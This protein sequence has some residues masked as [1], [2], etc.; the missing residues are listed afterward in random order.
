LQTT[1]RPAPHLAVTTIA[2]F[3]AYTAANLSW[4]TQPFQFTVFSTQSGFGSIAAGWILSSEIGLAALVSI[5]MG[6]FSGARTS[7]SALAAGTLLCVI[8][9]V[10]TVLVSSF[11]AIIVSR[12]VAGLGEGLLIAD[13]NRAVAQLDQPEKRYGQINA[14]MNLAGFLL[15]LC[16]PVVLAPLH[17]DRAIFALLAVATL[18]CLAA[19]TLYPVNAAASP[20][21]GA[22]AITGAHAITGSNAGT[23]A[24]SITRVPRG[25]GGWRGWTVCA[26]VLLTSTGVSS[27]YPV[28]ESLGR[29]SG[30]SEGSLDSAL[31]MA[32]IGAIIGSYGGAWIDARI[33][34]LGA[35]LW[36]GIGLSC[37]VALL[38]HAGSGW[39]FGAGMFLFGLFWFHGL[40][41]CLGLAAEVDPAGGC[42]AACGGAFLLGGGIGPVLG[43][44]QLDWSSGNNAL[45][46][47]SVGIFMAAYVVCLWLVARRNVLVAPAP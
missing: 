33:G 2:L 36:V 9:S 13:V 47:W 14:L 16:M 40:V 6:Y 8:G 32:Y 38:V 30:I 45:F 7:R 31:S 19:V 43:G 27:F 23:G 26:A 24:N 28:T 44:Y 21:T 1:S 11:W 39:E 42:A 3:G 34:R 4:F 37:A 46:A 17:I 25:I 20:R 41:T 18:I 29:A 22:N 35:A 15:L 12:I 10:T 5:A